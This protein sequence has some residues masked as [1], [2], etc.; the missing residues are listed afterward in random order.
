MARRLLQ[1]AASADAVAQ[2]ARIAR[3]ATAG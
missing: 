1:R 3:A 2:E